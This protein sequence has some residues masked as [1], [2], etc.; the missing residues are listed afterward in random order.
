MLTLYFITKSLQA[1]LCL[2]VGCG[3][4]MPGCLLLESNMVSHD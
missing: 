4:N 1:L 3:R 2:F